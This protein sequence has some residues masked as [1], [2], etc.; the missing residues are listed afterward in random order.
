LSNGSGTNKRRTKKVYRGQGQ[1]NIDA[2][3]RID[4]EQ[5][6]DE[7]QQNNDLLIEMNKNLASLVRFHHL[8]LEAFTQIYFS[9][10]EEQ[11][12][13]KKNYSLIFHIRC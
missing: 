12:N 8:Q 3:K 4:L 10:D 2:K 9:G 7:L 13:S 6:I 11:K 1:M 5:V